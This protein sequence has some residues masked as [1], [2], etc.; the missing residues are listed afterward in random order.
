MGEQAY[1][2]RDRHTPGPPSNSRR[3]PFDGA[4]HDERESTWAYFG[5][6]NTSRNT[7]VC[8]LGVQSSHKTIGEK[9]H[10]DEFS[11]YEIMNC[12]HEGVLLPHRVCE[13]DRDRTLCGNTSLACIQKP[14][15]T[16]QILSSP[17][18]CIQL[19]L[20]EACLPRSAL[21]HFCVVLSP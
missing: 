11:G 10:H 6:P 8:S 2:G 21:V 19:S 18:F 17:S 5:K 16:Q 20:S 3:Q 7:P 14:S 4:R 9:F 15:V 12:C 1:D 13:Q